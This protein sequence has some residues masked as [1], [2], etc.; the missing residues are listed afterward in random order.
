MSQYGLVMRGLLKVDNKVLILKRHPKSTTNPNKWEL[1]GG[2][3]DAGEDFENALVREFI[4]E[5]GLEI[6]MGDLISAVQEDFPHKKTV[7]IIMNAYINSKDIVDCE[8]PEVKISHEHIGWKWATLGEIK[9]LEVSGWFKKLLS[10][11]E[12]FLSL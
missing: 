11:K 5:T 1:P 10:E 9:E 12:L 2:K 6:E 8:L 3:V 4:E 7:A